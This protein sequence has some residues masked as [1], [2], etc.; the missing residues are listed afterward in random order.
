M[1]YYGLCKCIYPL[2]YLFI[3]QLSLHGIHALPRPNQLLILNPSLHR[4]LI[5]LNN[6]SAARFGVRR[7]CQRRGELNMMPV[8]ET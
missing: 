6:I 3:L 4:S 2:L 8:A 1:Q 7:A 5:Q